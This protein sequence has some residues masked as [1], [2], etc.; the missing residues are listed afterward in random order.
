MVPCQRFK[1]TIVSVLFL[2]LSFGQALFAQD[3]SLQKPKAYTSEEEI[4]G[5]VMSEKLDG[6]RGYW[7]GTQL[8]TRKGLPLNPPSWFI[9]NF[10]PF[11]LDGEL[12][13]KRGDFEFIQ[14]TVL[15][16]NPGNGW[17]KITY[18]IFE[19]PNEIGGFLPRLNKAKAWFETHK[20]THIKIIPQI[21]VK[22][23]SDLDLFLDEVQS[24]GGEGVIVKDPEMPYHTGRSAHVLKVKKF[25][26]M[27]GVVIGLNKGKGKYET[28][29]GSLTLKLENNIIFKLGTGFTDQNRKNPPSIGTI[30]T[31]KYYG[32]TK[33]G[34]PRFASFLRVRQD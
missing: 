11:E 30:V 18:N 4:T 22:D 1:Y 3:L 10:P 21:R 25:W 12:W 14:S 27:E 20:N 19:V 28:M 29:M 17:E 13:S 15:D 8:L 16:K 34:I 32:F 33:N 24:K 9:K 7:N 26:D 31:F 23:K 6:I 5:W 2:L